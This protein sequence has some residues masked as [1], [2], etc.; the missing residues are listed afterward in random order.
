MWPAR[1]SQPSLVLIKK[2]TI[3]GRLAS[4]PRGNLFRSAEFFGSHV[5]VTA[6]K[7][8]NARCRLSSSPQ[9][10]ERIDSAGAAR[11]QI[12]RNHCYHQKDQRRTSDAE[13]VA[14]AH[15]IQKTR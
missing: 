8:S 11:R 6:S 3:P 12:T 13:R 15:S 5:T 7:K 2:G 9:S 4:R 14:A 1:E 10:D